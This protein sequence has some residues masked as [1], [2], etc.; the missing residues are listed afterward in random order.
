SDERVSTPR[1]SVRPERSV[2]PGICDTASHYSES[3]GI[4]PD[5]NNEVRYPT[6]TYKAASCSCGCGTCGNTPSTSSQAKAYASQSSMPKVT[7][8]SPSYIT[9]TIEIFPETNRLR[10]EIGETGG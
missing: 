9:K 8:S 7:G 4:I 2:E 3:F 5:Y 6:E 10:I 1:P